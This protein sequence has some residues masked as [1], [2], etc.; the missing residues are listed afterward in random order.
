M[1]AET[2][3]R[4]FLPALS[5]STVAKRVARTCTTPMVMELMLSEIVDPESCQKILG[6]N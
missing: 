1:E 3:S 6:I 4:S 5:M 2:I